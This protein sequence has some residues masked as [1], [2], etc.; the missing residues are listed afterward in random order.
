MQAGASRLSQLAVRIS[1]QALLP[2]VQQMI[3]NIQQFMPDEMWIEQTGDMGAMSMK[4]TP[5][6]ITGSFNYQVS[7]GSLPYDK[8]AML[9]TWKEILFGVAQDPELRQEYALGQIFRYVAELGG[10]KNIDSFKRQQLPAGMGMGQNPFA[11]AAMADPG[12]Q[13]GMMPLGPAM[14]TNPMGG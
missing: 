11:T 1:A 10:A 7:D 14:P 3:S 13:P 5:E 9:E 8:S 12:N 4:L 2:L 6:M